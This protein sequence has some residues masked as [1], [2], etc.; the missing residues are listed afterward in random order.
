M[1][2]PSDHPPL[3]LLGLM[4]QLPQDGWSEGERARFLE[5]FVLVLDLCIPMRSN[6]TR[7]TAWT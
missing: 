5:A 3:A 2:E 6:Q 1:G 7:A 4:D